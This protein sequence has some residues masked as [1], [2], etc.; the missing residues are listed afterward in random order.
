M[1]RD[2]RQ[3]GNAGWG[4]A[5]LVAVVLAAAGCGG[6]RGVE[7]TGAVTRA[8]G[9]D[10]RSGE[11]WLE[12]AGGAVADVRPARRPIRDGRYAFDAGAG[13]QAGEWILRVQPPWTG[14]GG[15]PDAVAEAFKPLRRAV[16]IRPAGDG[17]NVFDVEVEPCT[18]GPTE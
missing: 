8:D 11:V 7:I 13:V 4:L 14:P 10:V 6:R 9:R 16:T 15:S 1:R 5:G 12:P 2:R 3:A 17:R 18:A